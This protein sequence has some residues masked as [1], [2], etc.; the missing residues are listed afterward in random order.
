MAKDETFLQVLGNDSSV[1]HNGSQPNELSLDQPTLSTSFDSNLSSLNSCTFNEILV[2]AVSYDFEKD[3]GSSNIRS[4]SLPSNSFDVSYAHNDNEDTV[5]S[6]TGSNGVLSST[7]DLVYTSDVTQMVHD[8]TVY[9]PQSTF[10][11]LGSI[12][13]HNRSEERRVGKECRSRWSPYH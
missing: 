3:K 1:V 8:S 6:T 12:G 7:C 4:L 13:L 11:Q 10:Q 9:F 5:V 2:T